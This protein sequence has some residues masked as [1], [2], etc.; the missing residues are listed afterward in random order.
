MKSAHH[1]N[2]SAVLATLLLTVA[3]TTLA[4]VPGA[5]DTVDKAQQRRKADATAQST[6]ATASAPELFPGEL[7]D[8]GPQA[9][10]QVKPRKTHFEAVADV[11]YLWTDNVLQTEQFKEDTTVLVST[12]QFAL[13]P[14]PYQLGC[15]EF[16]PRLGVRYQWYN[17]GLE[18]D[19]PFD[20]LDF[21]ARTIFVDGQFRLKCDVV[22]EAGLEATQLLDTDN[23]DD[24]YSELA[25]RWGIAWQPELCAAARLSV[26]YTGV[27]H[28][29]ETPFLFFTDMNDRLDHIMHASLV[30][31][32]CRNFVAQPYYRF[33]AT[34][35]R[36][37]PSTGEGLS[38]NLH[39]VGIGLHYFF[40]RWC[41]VRAFV[42]YD[43]QESDDLLV[44]NYRQLDAGGG[45]N[46]TLRF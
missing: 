6:Q 38:E 17:Y 41:S 26:G 37:N 27:Y 3:A 44:P 31:Q 28:A 12:V 46:F 8:L 10:L 1:M 35:Y 19:R 5:V 43:L 7:D 34:Q 16:S 15:G 36:E 40:T 29:S 23:H 9:L 22:L 13:A 18:T 32:C 2:L 45:L 21:N 30:I 33:K 4:Q 39:S 24:F 20:L 11:Q 25:P 42:N 14:D